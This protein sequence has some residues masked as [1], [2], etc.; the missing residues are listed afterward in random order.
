M[1]LN[2]HRN[3]NKV[4]L[5]SFYP[6]SSTGFGKNAVRQLGLKPYVDGSC[7]REPD[8]EHEQPCITGLCRP[9]FAEK[10]KENDL[11]IY[12]TNK[13]GIGSRKLIAILQVIKA[14][15]NQE[16]ALSFYREQKMVLPNNL[17]V[18]DNPP[19]PLK[20]TH[21]SPGKEIKDRFNANDSRNLNIWDGVYNDRAAKNPEVAICKVIYLNLIHP[22]DFPEI[23][24]RPLV[25]QTPPILNKEEI[26]SFF[27]I[28]ELQ[29]LKKCLNSLI[30]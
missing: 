3:L 9:K 19:K 24:R 28:R 15:K 6:L 27:S 7:R 23:G 17:M 1:T 5:T 20:E 2:L 4:Y 16:Q 14:V 21:Y 12:V 22:F 25:A 30:S 10:L 8:F 29:N 26:E 11:I 13:K 18:R